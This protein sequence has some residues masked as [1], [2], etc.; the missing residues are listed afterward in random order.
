MIHKVEDHI[1]MTYLY[2][3]EAG[4]TMREE[5]KRYGQDFDEMDISVIHGLALLAW[6]SCE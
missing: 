6:Y 2:I 5:F 1:T 4:D 3:N